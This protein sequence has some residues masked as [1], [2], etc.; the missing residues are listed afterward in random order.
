MNCEIVKDL[1][2]L[3]I[4]EVCSTE[5]KKEVESHLETC[6]DCK[7]VYENMIQAMKQKE[8]TQTLPNEKAIYLGIRQRMGNIILCAVVLIAVVGLAFGLMGEIGDHGWPQ[9]MFAIAF[10][11]P[12]TAFLLSMMNIF[13]LGEYPSRPWFCWISGAM[14]TLLC[15]GGDVVALLHYRFPEN[16]QD[17]IPYCIAIALVFGGISFVVSKLYSRFCNR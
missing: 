8:R 4:D 7:A 2:P 10:F 15:L 5:S 9:G 14:A 1:L 3:Y 17:L 6:K 12:C 13:F 16:W 11:I